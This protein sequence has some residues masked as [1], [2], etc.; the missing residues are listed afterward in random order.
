MWSYPRHANCL[1]GEILTFLSLFGCLLLERKAA[2]LNDPVSATDTP[3]FED[4]IRTGRAN[5][6]GILLVNGRVH[7]AR[8]CAQLCV[9]ASSVNWA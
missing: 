2:L 4:H 8:K 7:T 9:I 6:K 1:H 5:Y 3:V